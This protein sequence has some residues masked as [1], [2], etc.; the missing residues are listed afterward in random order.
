MGSATMTTEPS[1]PPAVVRP[2]GV[3]SPPGV[4]GPLGLEAVRADG[5]AVVAL[6]DH[7]VGAGLPE[8]RW[9]LHD[10]VVAGTRTIVVDL[11]ATTK[12]GSDALAALLGAHRACRARGGAVVLRNPGRQVN[13]LMRRTGLWRVFVVEK[14]GAAG[15]ER[16]AS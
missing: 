15:R 10:L 14:P 7:L 4:D 16:G 9:Q 1:G 5:R 6:D 2:V 11:S 13:D 8:L 3:E 12:V